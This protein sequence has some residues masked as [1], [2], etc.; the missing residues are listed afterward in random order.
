MFL[1]NLN[2]ESLLLQVILQL[3]IIIAA[4]RVGGWIFRWWGQPQVVGEIA[5]GLLLGPSCFGRLSPQLSAQTF[6]SETS[7]IFMVLGQLGLIFLMFIVGLEFDF[8]HLRTIGRTAAG[9]AL[10]GIV[11]PF[12][13]GAFLAYCIHSE[14]AAEYS[15]PGF[16][17]FTATALSITAI[18]I[19]GRIMMEFRI[20]QTPL[21]VL[22]ISAAAI[23]DAIGWMLL[24][25]V[26][27]AVHGSF[28]L[29]PLLQ[30]L[31]CT[32]IF[33]ATVFFVVRPIVVRWSQSVLTRHGGALPLVPFSVV[34]LLVLASAVFTN[35]IGI[36][37]IFGP[38]VLGA[39]LC[40]QHAL[41]TAIRVRLEEFVTVFFLPVFFTYTGL[42]TNIGTLDSMFLWVVCGLVV[43]VATVGKVVGCGVAARMGGLTWRDSASVAIMMNTR[44]LMG[45]IAVNIGRDLGVIPDSVFCMMV[46]MAIATTLITAP[47]LRRLLR[48][49]SPQEMG[50]PSQT[51]ATS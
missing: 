22:T 28:A 25:A 6:P 39:S 47:M 51:N 44:A 7:E 40:D 13:L 37:S 48:I 17:L 49:D 19:L 4:A 11:L 16:I 26:S 1:G 20:T 14:V 45:L 46:V 29:M 36:F 30:M 5:A 21:G 41:Q 27:A 32:A 34:L 42:R 31:G 43:I 33:I 23:D 15:R 35:W 12:G 3:I 9:V 50:S 24:A 18:P 38:F 2:S 8:G 10:A